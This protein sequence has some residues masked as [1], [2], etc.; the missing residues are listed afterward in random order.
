MAVDY[1][2]DAKLAVVFLV[3]NMHLPGI[4]PINCGWHQRRRQRRFGPGVRDH[5][6]L[7]YVLSGKGVYTCEG[8]AYPMGRQEVFLIRPG[9]RVSYEADA[10]TPWTYAWIGFEGEGAER[11]LQAA[12][13]SGTVRTAALPEM[14]EFFQ[15]LKQEEDGALLSPLMLCGRLY[16]LFDWLRQRQAGTAAL[17][18]PE[19]YARRAAEYIRANFARPITVEGLARTM[20]I[21]RRYFSRVF[22]EAMGVSPQAYLVGFRLEKAAALLADRRCTVGEAAKSVGY[23]DAFVFSRMYKRRFGL[24]PSATLA[25]GALPGA[26]EG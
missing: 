22:T 18:A 20:G 14:R 19:R 8:Q 12:G 7:H 1:M 25:A 13:F 17:P 23:E 3:D 21:D 26:E 5:Y 6:I 9:E 2:D 16:E 24:P 15:S 10:Q 11:L 4:N